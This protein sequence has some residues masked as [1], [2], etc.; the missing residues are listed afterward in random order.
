LLKF[1]EIIAKLLEALFQS[2][3]FGRAPRGILIS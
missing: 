1:V 3:K 2:C